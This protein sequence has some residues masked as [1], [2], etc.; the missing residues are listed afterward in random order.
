MYSVHS[1]ED[2]EEGVVFPQFVP[3]AP[4][5]HL[6]IEKGIKFNSLSKFKMV[7]KD[8]NIHLGKEVKWKKKW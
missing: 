7:V 2:E 5:S 1:E 6:M 4:F 8:Y 3:G